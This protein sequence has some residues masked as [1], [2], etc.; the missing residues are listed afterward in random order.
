MVE[1]VV[2][3]MDGVLLDSELIH[4]SA[5]QRALGS[6]GG[7]FSLDWFRANAPG[8]SRHEVLRKFASEM[9]IT[10]DIETVARAKA[11][12]VASILCEQEP[13]PV[14]ELGIVLTQIG[15]RFP[16]GVATASKSAELFLEWSNLRTFFDVVVTSEDVN[17]GKPAPDIFLEAASRLNVSPRSCVVIEDSVAGIQ[18]ARAAGMRVVGYSIVGDIDALGDAHRICSH[19]LELP[20]AL[21]WF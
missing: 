2:F 8:V 1:A 19:I 16:L 12:A 9:A 14:G 20:D 21:S 17:L 4:V 10:F 11:D 7:R 18:A 6:A 3:D 5:Y 15:A 13:P